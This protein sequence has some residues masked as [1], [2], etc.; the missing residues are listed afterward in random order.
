MMS[1]ITKYLIAFYTLFLMSLCMSCTDEK[2]E[3]ITFDGYNT[4]EITL[5]P[6]N[7][8]E[9]VSDEENEIKNIQAC[10]FKNGLL[11]DVFTNLEAISNNAYTIQLKET[12]GT[13]YM[14]ANV[15]ELI[16]IQ[17]FKQQGMT[18]SEWLTTK[19]TNNRE[20]AISFFTGKL[21]LEASI[22]GQSTLPIKLERGVARI[23][24]QLAI[25]STTSIKR[26]TLKN[27]SQESFLFTPDKT[28]ASGDVPRRD[29]DITFSC[30]L[31]K[32]SLGVAYVYE[33][34][35]Q[36]SKAIAE[37]ISNG[38]TYIKETN[39]PDTLKRNT[40]YKLTIRKDE[41]SEDFKVDIVEWENGE[42][43]LQPDFDSHITINQAQS[44]LPNDV[45]V[46]ES[47]DTLSLP[48]RSMN[49]T[50]VLDCDDELEFAYC[51]Y[52]YITVEPANQPASYTTMNQFIIHKPLLPPGYPQE[53]AKI[54]F[55]R[56]GLQS[57]Y[58]ED[59]I[60]F[61]LQE[62]PIRVEGLFFDRTNYTC[63]FG[64][65]VDNELGQFVLP[66]DMEIVAEFENEDPWIK[67]EKIS[68]NTN[69]YRILGG[70]KPNDPKADGRSQKAQLIVRHIT[71]KQQTE[72]YT[73]IRRNYGLPVTYLNGIWW[74]RYNAIGNSKEFDEQIL[75][76]NDPARLSG[77]T[78]QEYLKTCTQD[79]FLLLW[80]AAYEGNTGIALKA[81]YQD[82]KF[83]LNDWRSSESNHINKEN[84]QALSPNGYEMPT[85]EDYKQIFSSF[86]IPTNWSG[87][88]PQ[89]GGGDYRC[90]IIL[91]KRS[92]IQ[93]D[94]HDLNELWAFSI[95]SIK[96]NGEEPL[97]FYGVGCQ[98]DSNGINSNWILLACY[99]PNV[100]GWLVRG[101]NG[102]L[103]HNGA[104]A[105]NTRTI[106]FKKSPVEYIYE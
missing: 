97:T 88:N 45:Q 19:L 22:N 4:V 96:E 46:S 16:D 55:R 2:Q 78:V 11:T 101:S 95:R 99:N 5:S 44:V 79:E 38:Q 9:N 21:S 57:V 92:G 51:S 73:V 39:L 93:L 58:D 50:L 106:R 94:G 37:I 69:T 66:E 102:S 40:I 6:F 74:C 61:T 43:I 26:I 54:Y 52:P 64:C 72:N 81:V 15:A 10:L 33:Q 7:N 34:T 77:K 82:N 105:N 68:D 76:A 63:D 89:N 32:D 18:E 24:L 27:I 91:E 12:Y 104:S 86:I 17:Q 42:S 49:F 36:Q 59:C 65:Y 100:T 53:T 3:Q 35:S 31:S 48:S 41:G 80:N 13:F 56:K 71:D 20:K 28:N 90:E 67:I 83:T 25:P 8:G 62:N 60:A 47:N 1:Q 14:V 84:P 75:S 30:P 29:M 87:F 23:D 85:F 98:W 103:E 70:W